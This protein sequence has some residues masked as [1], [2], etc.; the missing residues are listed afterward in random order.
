MI[1]LAVYLVLAL[2]AFT[3]PTDLFAQT[4]TDRLF[5][6][7]NLVAW[8]IVPFDGQKR[9]PAERAEMLA[10]L[11]VK[12]VAYDWR[13]EHVPTF[14]QEILEYQRRGLEYFAFWSVHEDAFKLF[15][16]HDMQPQIWQIIPTPSAQSQDA[17]VAEAA[18]RMLPL[19]E[20][21]RKLGSKLGLYN[22]G[23]WSGEP[24]NLV[25]V[26]EFLRKNHH[27][28]HVG[29]VYNEH[30]AHDQIDSFPAAI[31]LMKPYLLCLNLNG[32][33]KGA[34]K[35]LPLGA[36]DFELAM[37]RTI[38]DSGYDGPIG[39]IGHTQDDVE[40]RLQ[41]NLDGL[42]WLVPQLDG[43]PADHRPSFRTWHR[44]S[45]PET[46]SEYSSKRVQHWVNKARR[47]GN[48]HRGLI[49]FASATSACLS[50]HKLGDHGGDVGP[51]L[52]KIAPTRK[53]EEI[54]ES[55]VWPNRHV[56]KQYVTYQVLTEDGTTYRGFVVSRDN[57]HL[58]LRDPSR[59]K[60]AEQTI[61]IDTIET[62]QPSGTIMPDNLLATMSDQQA[63]DLFRFLFELG[64]DQGI[65]AAELASVLMHA[66][67]H[68]H[69]PATFEHDRKPLDPDAWPNW[70]AP[71]NRGR[72]YD[73]YAKQAEHFRN[74]VPVEP[75]LAEYPGL[76]GGQ[77]G[78]WGNQNE[79]TWA[80]NA[81]NEVKI[82]SVQCGVFR[83]G[84]VTVPRGVCIRLGGEDQLAVCFNPDTLSYDA[85]WKDGFLAFSSVRHGFMDGVPMD[86]TLV[87]AGPTDPIKE[88]FQY[89]GFY[90]IG[91]RVVFS[92][93]IG[94][95]EFLDSPTM[96]AG[97][98]D[99]QLS[100]AETHP[101]Y[102]KWQDQAGQWPQ[103]FETT[104]EFGQGSPYAVDTI[105]LP[106]KNP[107]NAT[108]FF[109]GHDFEPDGS[110]IVATMRGDVWRVS[111]FEYPSRTATWRR[112]ASGL[113]QPQGVVVDEDG[114]FVLG[115][116]QITRLHDLNG[117]GETDFY[118]CFSNA[119]QTSIAGHDFICGLQRD[120]DGNFYIASGNQGLVQISSDGTR[121]KV[122]A[123][124]FR[125]PDGLGVTADGIVTVP[126][127]EGTW[128]PASMI[129]AMKI[130]SASSGNTPY[131]GYP[132]PK[133]GQIPSL[134]LV[135]LPRGL[136]NS[137]GGQIPITSDRWGPL[138]GQLIHFSYGTGSHFLL[139]R[140][141][142]GGQMQGAVVP[143]PGE[144]LSGAHR[145]R[146]NPV[147]GQLY[148]TG[149][150]GWGSY[151]P[152]GGCLQRVRYTGDEVQLPVGIRVHQN[153]VA[154]TFTSEL[155]PEVAQK[156]ASH[157][158]QCWNYRY[159][160]AYGSPEF[161]TR[162]DGV[163][164]HDT[165]TIK[166]AHLAA[167]RK[168]L[169]LELPDIQP[170]NQL[171]LRVQ[172]KPDEF[173]DLFA[174]VHELDK[175]YIELPSY[176]PTDKQINPHPILADI[177]RATKRVPNPYRSKIEGARAIKVV[178]GSNLTFTTNE[179][180]V[181]ASEP[182]AV[183][184]VNPDVVPHN[185]ALIAPGTL[186]KIGALTNRLISD[187]DAA[188]RHYVPE[189]D[190]VLAYTDIVLPKE[191]ST[192][193]FLAPSEPGRYPFL[194]T[195]PGHWPVMNGVMIVE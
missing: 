67:V 101:L 173:C 140:D 99:R 90:R 48:A 168:T 134:P 170:V 157:F 113:H 135:Y 103:S 92:Y 33:A 137:A 191:S 194:C 55:V 86:G 34:E 106:G 158:A 128:T 160:S 20:R 148:V 30:H 100:P 8:C 21:T 73:F 156:A 126:C 85:V 132:G 163:R 42:D 131:F 138:T 11:G 47:T 152:E 17:K 39:I 75:L 179:I 117:D 15:E 44:K 141:E 172:T 159:S 61:A 12:R 177:A 22:H 38:R 82:G 192:I 122:I 166:S 56:E 4:T 93:R 176:A 190:D 87:T 114:I 115:R 124:G 28:D 62:E 70:N 102:Q 104:I 149:M 111:N 112:I 142:V 144:F 183:T 45:E 178:T 23:G 181:S 97:K 6:R 171:H 10:K 107:W 130:D 89:H 9:N 27:A 43:T 125:N 108:F 154:L 95:Q 175:P 71:V 189:S 60:D 123:T 51:D 162:H 76:D 52:T 65:P 26:C 193:Q 50:C 78:H 91:D 81:W 127:S 180:R 3:A 186:E 94:G 64:T 80:S 29:I 174:T 54:V 57:E 1:R 145:G 169:F 19:V 74:T 63:S 2:S 7:D 195:F 155:D 185:W 136:D 151:T 188:M 41:D 59:T 119:Y 116:D 139:L 13:D 182:L 58:V 32:M 118:E 14:E 120:S 150:Q 164:G 18:L 37:L 25:A 121:A 184:L 53:P 167:D 16:K 49:A 153:G 24:E 133:D 77:Q 83:G 161:S 109:G 165:V 147:D 69:G 143:L 187:P 36:G 40:L 46:H 96:V 98:F 110:A 68:A 88:P 72:D 146:F 84:D 129:C 105:T 79:D 66:N 35:I 31:A 5:A